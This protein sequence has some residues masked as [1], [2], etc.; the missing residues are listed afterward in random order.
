MATKV[1][2]DAK[3]NK[4]DEFYTSLKD[5]EIEL[6]HYK[7]Y[8]NNKIILC[9]C[10]DPYESNFFKYFAINFNYLGLKKL[11]ATCYDG[12]V[13]TGSE[14]NLFN[15]LETESFESKAYKIEITEI[16]D[17]NCDGV[18]DFFDVESLLKSNKNVL[19]KLNGNGDFRS[20]ECLEL[21]V[22][23][24]IVV[25]NPPFSL[26]R[27]YVNLLVQYDKLFLLIGNTN[28]LSYKEIFTLFKEDRIRTGYTNFNSGMFF[29]VPDYYDKF[30]HIDSNGNKIA[31]V[32]T[33][34][35]LTNLPVNKHNIELVL[36]KKYSS[37]EYPTYD[38]YDAI[39]VNKYTDIPCDYFGIMGVPITFL[40]KY[41]PIQFEIL[42]LAASA[43]YKPEV[44]GIEF[45]GTK[46]ARPLING[47]N[48][49]A[50]VFV[51]R[52]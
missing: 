27:E 47:K 28:A 19:T 43:G 40:D 7:E 20:K 9:N 37:E 35:W 3:N 5:I 39:N 49:Y 41:N 44:V 6:K 12:S 23:A 42:G 13:I 18:I 50:R 46:D 16:P 51:R 32:S 36:Y 24:D 25:T 29:I 30:H 21:L 34:C 1:M 38:N 48:T 33:S 52:R 14:L 2:D 11:I 45:K 4:L 10:D 22:E 15:F 17:S 8:F 31:R 26:F